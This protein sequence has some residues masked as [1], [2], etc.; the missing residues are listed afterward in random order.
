LFIRKSKANAP[1]AMRRPNGRQPHSITTNFLCLTATIQPHVQAVTLP[2]ITS[3][4]PV[5]DAMN[6]R[7]K[8]FD[9]SIGKKASIN[10]IDAL[11]VI[12]VV[13]QTRGI[14]VSTQY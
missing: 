13:K 14:N 12:E 3:A 4:I 1:N 5:M 6:I 10:L 11:N 8:K 2:M 7:L 9:V